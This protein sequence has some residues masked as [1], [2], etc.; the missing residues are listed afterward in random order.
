MYSMLDYAGIK[1]EQINLLLAHPDHKS[2]SDN[3]RK[4]LR[5]FLWG[6]YGLVLLPGCYYP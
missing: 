2:L 1:E 4:A 6:R 5:A 3:C